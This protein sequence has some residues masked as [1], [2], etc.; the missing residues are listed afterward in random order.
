MLEAS[1]PHFANLGDKLVLRGVLHNTTDLAGEADVELQLDATA[2]AAE[3]KRH[4]TLPAKGSVPV[5]FPTEIVATGKAKWRWSVHFVS[6]DK[7]TEFRDALQSEVNVGYPAPLVREVETKRVESNEAELKRISDPQII[8]GSGQATV[9]VANTRVIELRESLRY[10]LHYPYGCLE[11]T[12]S[13]L[14]PWLMVRDLRETLPE[15]AKT[16]DEIASAVNRGVNRLMSMQT[17]YWR[18]GFLAG[19]PGADALGQRLWWSRAG[20]GAETEIFCSGSGDKKAVQ[21]SERATSRHG[22]R[23]RR[24]MDSPRNV[25]RSIRWP[26]AG[27]T[28]AGLSR[29]AFSKTREIQR[30]RSGPCRAGGDREQRAESDDR[31][32]APSRLLSSDA[33][34]DQFFGSVA[35]ENALHL[36]AWTLHRTALAARGRAR[37]RTFPAAQQR[38]LEHDAGERLVACSRSRLTCGRSKRATRM[39]PARSCGAKR[40]RLSPSAK[41]SRSSA[42]RFRS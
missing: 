27:Q 14:L 18:S 11:Q 29:S 28:G 1:L 26:L 33:Y 35:R 8:E 5:D 4:V 24:V 21:L 31:R 42:R 30:G 41:T 34:V 9:N 39:R 32:A 23:T 25:S 16:D 6:N 40:P 36:L 13:S 2:K 7:K 15:L 22:E 17:S 20:A 38:P 37:G 10:L 19:R 12:T 3:V